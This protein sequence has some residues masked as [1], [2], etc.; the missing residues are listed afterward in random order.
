MLS[1]STEYSNFNIIYVKKRNTQFLHFQFLGQLSHLL[2]NVEK[3]HEMFNIR[4][5]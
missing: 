1:A 2:F 3:F 5:V 4:V